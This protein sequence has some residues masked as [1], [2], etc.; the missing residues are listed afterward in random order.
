MK[1][2]NKKLEEVTEE[3]IDIEDVVLNYLKDERVRVHQFAYFIKASK[4]CISYCPKSCE[5]IFELIGIDVSEPVDIKV[6][7]NKENI[8][9]AF[10]DFISE[11][12]NAYNALDFSKM[13]NYTRDIVQS[14]VPLPTE[15]A[16]ITK[17]LKKCDSSSTEK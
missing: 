7:Y 4:V 3:T 14:F 11:W 13:D 2:K 9:T 17:A 1:V 8:S 15:I 16:S 5:N 10:S 6:G 12:I